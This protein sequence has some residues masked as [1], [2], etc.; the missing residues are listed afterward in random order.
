MA[1]ISWPDQRQCWSSIL[2]GFSMQRLQGPVE[3]T[4][5]SPGRTG[6]RHREAD[7]VLQG[8]EE[9]IVGELVVEFAPTF[10]GSEIMTCVRQAIGDLS[11]SIS[12]E[13]L[14]ELAARLA[15]HRLAAAIL[16]GPVGNG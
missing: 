6:I 5:R 15:H 9:G 10:A 8:V 14:P 4:E 7:V 12:L 11:G 1:A 2:K 3:S 16:E 13:A